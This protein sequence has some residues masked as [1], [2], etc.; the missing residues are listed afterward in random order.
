MVLLVNGFVAPW[1]SRSW[2][3]L[4]IVVLWVLVVVGGG[5]RDPT[6]LLLHLGGGLALAATTKRTADALTIGY[7]Q[8]AEARRAAERRAELLASVLRTQDLD[9]AVVLRSA[10]HGLLALGFDVA[11]VREVD[12]AAGVAR[13]VEGA[14]K[15]D[16]ALPEVLS[17]DDHDI[18]TVLTT[19]RPRFVA[20]GPRTRADLAGGELGAAVLYPVLDGDEVIAIV[21]AGTTGDDLHPDAEEAAELLLAQAGE[22]LLRA[23]AYR[24]DRE[25]TRELQRLQRHTQDFLSTVSHELRTP[26]TVVQGLAAT[27]SDRWDAL[28]H[29]RRRDLLR[30]IDA[31]ADRLAVMVT[32][33]L[34]TS[35]VS[36]DALQVRLSEVRL[37]PLLRS[38]VDR[39]ADVLSGHE[40]VLDVDDR[41]YVQ[42]DPV[43]FE[44]VIDNLL[45]NVATHTPSGTTARVSARSS[46]DRI[47]IEVVDDGPGVDDEDLPHLLERFYR[48]GDKSHRASTR[49]LGLGLA[50]AAEVVTNH[51]GRLE[52]GQ[53]PGGGAS[54]SFDVA[55][56]PPR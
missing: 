12:R 56:A 10:A 5:E 24:A 8:A 45:V 17:L 40:V 15:A 6:V 26:L 20:G 55:A 50:L 31:N 16:V 46:G 53:G 30:R 41:L 44:H 35:Q 51:G 19:A 38:A 48:G 13:L 2:L 23:R 43:L 33:L 37:D 49:G 25:T 28:E 14:T 3:M 39:L 32:R 1:R 4:W 34:D 7:S 18:A 22:A 47:V 54:F 11:A 9:P 42:V 52:V 21:G 29:E 36:R 27:L